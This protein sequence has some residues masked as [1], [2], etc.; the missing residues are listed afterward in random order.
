MNC[1]MNC[2]F[3]ATL[4]KD[5]PAYS[6]QV[7]VVENFLGDGTISIDGMNGTVRINSST[8]TGFLYYRSVGDSITMFF[9][10]SESN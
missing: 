8:P 2:T 9:T 4:E 5:D 1:S 6:M 3:T 7:S 10:E